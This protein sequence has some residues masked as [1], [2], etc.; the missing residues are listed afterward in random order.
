VSRGFDRADTS[1]FAAYETK[2]KLKN[3]EKISTGML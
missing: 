3:E 2:R 1:G